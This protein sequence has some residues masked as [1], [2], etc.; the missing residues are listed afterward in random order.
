MPHYL[1]RVSY[2]DAAIKSQLEHHSDRE[3]AARKLV[4]ANGGKMIGMYFS[5]GE[6]DAYILFEAP[7]EN[8]IGISAILKATGAFQRVD[9]VRMYSA[10]EREAA[11][12]NAKNL[13]P[14][15]QAPVT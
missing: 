5:Y 13:L 2:S 4:D 10:Q 15:Y 12:R 6:F 9:L 14:N 3:A 7:D 8:M 11:F 1:C